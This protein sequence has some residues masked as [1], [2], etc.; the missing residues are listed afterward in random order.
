MINNTIKLAIDKQATHE[1]YAA[2]SYSALS[3]WCEA[4]DYGGYAKF[5]KQQATEE[6]EHA[7]KFFDHVLER[8]AMPTIGTIVAPKSDYKDLLEVA[9]AALTLEQAN[10]A[11]IVPA[12]FPPGSKVSAIGK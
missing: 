2:H 3:M 7:A 8:G 10:T 11:G 4:N 1:L 9:E 5:F 6:F 12:K